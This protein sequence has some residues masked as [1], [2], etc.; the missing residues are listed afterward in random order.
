MRQERDAD[1]ELPD[2]RGAFEDAAAH[3]VLVKIEGERQAGYAAAD[4]CNVH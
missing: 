4:D 1:A 2:F 3:S